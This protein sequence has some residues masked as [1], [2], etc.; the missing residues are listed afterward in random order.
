MIKEMALQEKVNQDV[1]AAHETLDS[2]LTI[3]RIQNFKTTNRNLFIIEIEL[4][5]IN[6]P[7]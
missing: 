5:I 6:N 3:K 2:F 7:I 4:F 1:D